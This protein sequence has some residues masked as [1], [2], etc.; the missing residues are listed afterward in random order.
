VNLKPALV[1]LLA[2]VPICQAQN[3]GSCPSL[4]P[5]LPPNSSTLKQVE[6][7]PPPTPDLKYFGTVTLLTVIS[8][9]GY[10]CSTQVLQGISKEIDKKAETTIRQSRFKPAMKEGHA[11]TAASIV[12]VYYW[13]TSTGEIVSDPPH[14]TPPVQPEP[15]DKK[16]G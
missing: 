13:T 16:N 14:P 1:V 4:P 12:R 11:V 3:K 15:A 10:V 8:D 9:K 2:M 7:P 6:P 5:P